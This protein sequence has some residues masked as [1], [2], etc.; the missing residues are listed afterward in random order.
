MAEFIRDV[1][2][3]H[4]VVVNYNNSQFSIDFLKSLRSVLVTETF[5]IGIA[6]VIDNNSCSLEREVLNSFIEGCCE[7]GAVNLIQSDENIGYF[8]AINVGIEF[9]EERKNPSDII[10]VGNNDLLVDK[11]FLISLES[12]RDKVRDLPVIVPNLIDLNNNKQNPHLVKPIGKFRSLIH[13]LYY[14]NY[15]FA[16]VITTLVRLL[17]KQRKI[18]DYDEGFIEEGY[19]A[20]YILTPLFF[21]YFPKLFAPTFLMYEESALTYQLKSIGFRVYYIPSIRVIHL[22][23]S[24]FSLYPSKFAWNCGSASHKVMKSI[25]LEFL[26][27][28]NTNGLN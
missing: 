27:F 4:F 1:K 6:V 12:V 23:H 26:K 28:R 13:E 17:K 15:F 10:A 2:R 21:K 14:T 20:F 7:E 16:R 18:L 5:E 24:S 22:E 19:G 11:E 9:L 25:D 3:V 8:P